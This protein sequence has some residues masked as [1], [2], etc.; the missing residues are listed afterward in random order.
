[1][2]W[3]FSP[4]GKTFGIRPP[5]CSHSTV[6]DKYTLNIWEKVE[7]FGQNGDLIFLNNRCTIC[8]KF[9]GQTLFRQWKAPRLFPGCPNYCIYA[10][11]TGLALLHVISQLWRGWGWVTSDGQVNWRRGVQSTAPDSTL[12]LLPTRG[13]EEKYTVRLPKSLFWNTL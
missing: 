13:W 9:V 11:A 7:I 10:F 5:E 2:L 4:R 12:E 8:V 6:F 3:D 1:M